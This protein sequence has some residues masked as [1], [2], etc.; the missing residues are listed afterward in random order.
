MTPIHSPTGG[1]ADRNKQRRHSR[2]SLE[3][4]ISPYA[5]L[6]ATV[7]GG[8]EHSHLVFSGRREAVARARGGSSLP[9]SAPFDDDGALVHFRPKGGVEY[10]QGARV[11]LLD[12]KVELGWHGFAL[13]T[14]MATNVSG[15]MF[16]GA[17]RRSPR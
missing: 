7:S 11:V 12:Q 2:F 10:N 3:L 17:S 13:A 1:V 14:V 8:G 5:V 16:L 9:C 15:G 4:P 6:G